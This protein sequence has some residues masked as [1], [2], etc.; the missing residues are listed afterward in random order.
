MVGK[1]TINNSAMVR[2]ALSELILIFIVI[3]IPLGVSVPGSAK[4]REIPEPPLIFQP[5]VI[6]RGIL[7]QPQA[8]RL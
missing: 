3:E 5:L 1:R 6:A 7:P 2:R 8:W 4:L